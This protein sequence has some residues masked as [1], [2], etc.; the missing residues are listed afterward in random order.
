M[1]AELKGEPLWIVA[2][3]R[4]NYASDE[5]Q[6][7]Q[8]ETMKGSWRTRLIGLWYRGGARKTCSIPSVAWRGRYAKD[9]TAWRRVRWGEGIR[10]TSFDHFDGFGDD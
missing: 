8:G 10:L 1:G 2:A 4:C 3:T 5:T 7:V 9:M 6:Y